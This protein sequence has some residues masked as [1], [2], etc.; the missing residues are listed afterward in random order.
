MFVCERSIDTETNSVCVREGENIYVCERERERERERES[1]R[2]IQREIEREDL[3]SG[4]QSSGKSPSY[5][6]N[7]C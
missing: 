6:S 4:V 2:E 3:F 1:E 5:L 7:L